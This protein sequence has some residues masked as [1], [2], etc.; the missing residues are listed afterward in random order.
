YPH[1]RDLS[2]PVHDLPDADFKEALRRLRG[3]PEEVLAHDELMELLLPLLR[4]DF[5]MCDTYEP[6]PREPLSCPI[7]AFAGD[8]D[9]NVRPEQLAAW[10]EL[11]T[12]EFR[13]VTLPGGH[14]LLD[15]HG[16][17][18]RREIREFGAEGAA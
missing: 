16:D 3:T 14:F 10:G 6:A 9:P 15:V 5:E 7:V 17:R 2:S 11:T 18:I 4:A 12:G 1:Q 13:A 8:E